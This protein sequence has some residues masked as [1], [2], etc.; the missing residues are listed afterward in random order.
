M[1]G[2]E[3]TQIQKKEKFFDFFSVSYQW[4]IT[5]ML[6]DCTGLRTIKLTELGCTF[7]EAYSQ[8][9]DFYKERHTS[10]TRVYPY[11]RKAIC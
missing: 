7:R 9:N 11:V 2:V 6:C 3:L 4:R 8:V 5:S 1:Y 10:I